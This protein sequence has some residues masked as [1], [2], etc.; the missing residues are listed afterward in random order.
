PRRVADPGVL[1]SGAAIAW[2]QA[3]WRRQTASGLWHGHAVVRLRPAARTLSQ[4]GRS[5]REKTGPHWSIWCRA[6][7]TIR[8]DEATPAWLAGGPVAGQPSVASTDECNA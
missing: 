1:R 8:R 3:G 6:G 2:R 7:C 4:A 5:G